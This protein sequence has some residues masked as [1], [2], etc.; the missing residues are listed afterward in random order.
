MAKVKFLPYIIIGILLV[1]AGFSVLNSDSNTKDPEPVELPTI[2]PT[3]QQSIETNNVLGEDIQITA[4]AS[5]ATIQTTKGE[6]V[7]ALF[8]DTAP[9]TVANFATK[10]QS[11]FYNNLTFHRVENWVIQ[12]GDPLGNGTGGGQMPTE[13]N[14]NP[15]IRGSVGV[16]RGGNIQISNDSQFFI[17]KNDSPHLDGQYTNFGQ[18][19]SGLDVIDSI[20][21]GDKITSITIQ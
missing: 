21:I 4:T 20:E 12:G 7:I 19:S 10:S 8:P 3:T 2:I 17:T 14:N 6:I 18:A 15:F 16:A 11:G 1:I 9:N 5:T 13:L